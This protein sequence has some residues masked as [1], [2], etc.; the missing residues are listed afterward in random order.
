ML[1]NSLN[2][3][4]PRRN[5]CMSHAAHPTPKCMLQ[6]LRLADFPISHVIFTPHH[7]C[8]HCVVVRRCFYAALPVVKYMKV[9]VCMSHKVVQIFLCHIKARIKVGRHFKLVAFVVFVIFVAL[10]LFCVC[11]FFRHASRCHCPLCCEK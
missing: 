5:I 10:L 6:S 7:C 2:L 11:F 3:M 8:W 4:Q 9:F 1:R